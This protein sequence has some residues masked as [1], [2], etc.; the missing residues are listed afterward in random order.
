MARVLHGRDL[1]PGR[2]YVATEDLVVADD[3]SCHQSGSQCG[4]DVKRVLNEQ[5][6][7]ARHRGK[8]VTAVQ[9]L[10]MQVSGPVSRTCTVC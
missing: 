2:G 7:G 9:K 6:G 8:V 4:M 3:R 1:V 5:A 10:E